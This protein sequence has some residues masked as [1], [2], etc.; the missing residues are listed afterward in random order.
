MLQVRVAWILT[1][2]ASR[3]PEDGHDGRPA[4]GVPVGRD[5]V[6]QLVAHPRALPLRR[7]QLMSQPDG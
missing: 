7:D 2:L 3:S 6:A 5:A 4:S 1:N